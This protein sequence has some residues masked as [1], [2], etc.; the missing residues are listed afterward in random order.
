[1]PPLVQHSKA[2]AGHRRHAMGAGAAS[3]PGVTVLHLFPAHLRRRSGSY[4][5]ALAGERSGGRGRSGGAWGRARAEESHNE[6][7][8]AAE[9]AATLGR[10]RRK[11]TEQSVIFAE[12][13][14]VVSNLFQLHQI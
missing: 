1:M 8:H 9:K 11:R 14:A 2:G 5:L 6:A 4:A 7:A 10:R 13:V 3:L 12:L